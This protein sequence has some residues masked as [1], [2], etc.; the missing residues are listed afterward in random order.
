MTEDETI[1]WGLHAERLINDDSFIDLFEKV[2]S[3]LAFEMLSTALDDEKYRQQLYLTFNGMRAFSDRLVQM[4]TA[5]LHIEQERN[6]ANANKE[7]D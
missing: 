4:A 2:K 7:S 3:D 5:K 1:T 6:E